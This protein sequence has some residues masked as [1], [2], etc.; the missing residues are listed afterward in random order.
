MDL[1]LGSLALAFLPVRAAFR[2]DREAFRRDREASFQ[3]REAS[4][5]DQVACLLI[6][7]FQVVHSA[8]HLA[9][10]FQDPEASFQDLQ[11][12]HQLASFPSSLVAFLALPWN[13]EAFPGQ[14]P[15]LN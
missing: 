13:L 5:Q 14:D 6:A 15:S 10:S 4:F 3:G 8:I 12:F 2:Q 1:G 7:S 9:A 11:A